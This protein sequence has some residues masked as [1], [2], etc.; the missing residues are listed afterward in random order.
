MSRVRVHRSETDMSV[1]PVGAMLRADPAVG[2]TLS[3]DGKVMELTGLGSV[4]SA[5]LDVLE[6]PTS[7]YDVVK[8]T[9]YAM[10]R[11]NEVIAASEKK[12]AQQNLGVEAVVLFEDACEEGWTSFLRFGRDGKEWRL[13]VGS[14]FMHDEPEPNEWTLLANASRVTRGNAIKALP[15]LYN[16]MIDAAKDETLT[17]LESVDQAE[18]FLA[19]L[20]SK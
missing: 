5:A 15:K 3:A 2:V 16:A 10:A 4:G 9:K 14:S 6:G 19:K 7:A 8:V 13:F 17:L 20:G 12:F 11:L 1:E 18:A